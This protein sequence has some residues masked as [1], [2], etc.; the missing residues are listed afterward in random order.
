MITHI[1]MTATIVRGPDIHGGGV[2]DTG[3]AA[4]GTATAIVIAPR[5]DLTIVLQAATVIAPG[6]DPEEED[7]AEAEVDGLHIVRAEAEVLDPEAARP[8][9]AAVRV[10]VAAEA[11]ADA[12]R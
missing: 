8:V 4:A 3:G 7:R 6:T 11:E 5:T 12:N 10:A 2:A 1:I 9:V